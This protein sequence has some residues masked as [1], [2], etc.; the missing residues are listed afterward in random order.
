M[1]LPEKSMQYL[2]EHIPELAEAAIKQA[3]WRALASGYTVLECENGFLVEV[4]PDGSRKILKK[5]QPPTKVKI[6]QR[7]IIQ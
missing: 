5:L 6:G 2:E 1:S 4:H 7:L 3:Y